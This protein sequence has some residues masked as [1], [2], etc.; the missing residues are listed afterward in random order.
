MINRVIGIICGLGV[1]VTGIAMN[2]QEPKIDPIAKAAAGTFAVVSP[3]FQDNSDPN[4]FGINRMT[5]RSEHDLT[6]TT[7]GIDRTGK[8]SKNRKPIMVY[9]PSKPLERS[10][11]ENLEKAGRDVSF[12][13]IGVGDQNR[14]RGPAAMSRSMEPGPEI[15]EIR[16]ELIVARKKPRSFAAAFRKG[17]WTFYAA[18]V[19]ATNAKC[20]GCH[21]SGAEAKTGAFSKNLR[22]GDTIGLVVIAVKTAK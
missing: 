1:V 19:A 14:M 3:R 22:I 12:Y 13:T 17:N 11:V 18:S 7:Y 21:S 8:S 9:N 6:L 2:P 4:K 15:S 16:N 20:L 5:T 10:V